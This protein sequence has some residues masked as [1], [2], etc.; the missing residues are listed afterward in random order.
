M[1]TFK[2][3][4]KFNL[5]CKIHKSIH[6]TLHTAITPKRVRKLLFCLNQRHTSNPE[7]LFC[8]FPW[9]WTV[10][11]CCLSQPFH[12]WL[13]TI[14][15]HTNH[16][17][18]K[19]PTTWKKRSRLTCFSDTALRS[20]LKTINKISYRRCSVLRWYNVDFMMRIQKELLLCWNISDSIS[21]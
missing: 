12:T 4:L 9:T 11:S 15:V 17:V 19:M 7:Q 18:F 14:P 13:Q 21:K 5:Y 10:T 20:H 1:Q 8:P 16:Q 6:L 3:L 2:I